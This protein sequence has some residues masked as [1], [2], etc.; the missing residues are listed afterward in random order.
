MVDREALLRLAQALPSGT[1]LPVPR[2]WVLELL[3]GLDVPKPT[4]TALELDLTPEETGAALHRSPVTIRA[5]ANAGLFKGAYRLRGRQWRIPRAAGRHSSG[6]VSVTTSTSL[7]L[8]LRWSSLDTASPHA[9]T[10]WPASTPSLAM[11]GSEKEWP[12]DNRRQRTAHN[13]V[14]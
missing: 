13:A 14:G 10:V 8:R 4:A 11:H 7:R 3:G 6:R 2:E 12:N 5:Y 1:A 9:F